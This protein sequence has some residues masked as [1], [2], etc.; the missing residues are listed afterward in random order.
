MGN[1]R[2]RRTMNERYIIVEGSEK[3]V[4][5]DNGV[6]CFEFRARIPYYEGVPLSQIAFVKIAVN[7]EDI[8]LVAKTDEVFT[9]EE[10]TTAL[11]FF[12]EYGEGLRMR[13]M[14]GGLPKGSH[15]LDVEIGISVIYAKKGFGTK[16]WSFFEI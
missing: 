1:E 9:L 14:K 8:R 3:N 5:L 6:Q 15:R 12:W 10:A 7:V 16:S 4:M 2:G 11:N 13:V